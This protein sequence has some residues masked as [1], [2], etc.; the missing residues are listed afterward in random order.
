MLTHKTLDV[1]ATQK[2]HAYIYIATVLNQT[3]N[4]LNRCVFINYLIDD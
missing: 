3:F 1:V 4:M 2:P